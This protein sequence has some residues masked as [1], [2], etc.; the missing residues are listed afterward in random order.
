MNAMPEAGK[1]PFG[2]TEN[3]LGPQGEP[4]ASARIISI[5]Q[6]RL[7]IFISAVCIKPIFP[8]LLSQLRGHSDGVISQYMRGKEKAKH[9]L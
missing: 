3:G 7:T 5:F 4:I 6:R 8:M 9:C 2:R 1:G